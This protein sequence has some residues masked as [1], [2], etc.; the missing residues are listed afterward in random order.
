VAEL[1]RL[2]ARVGDRVDTHVLMLAPAN[3]TDHWVHSDLWRAAAAL[4]GVQ[5]A[6]DSRGEHARLF[7]SSTSGQVLLYDAGGRLQFAGGITASRGHEGGNAGRS[8]LESLIAGSP[9]TAATPVFGC[10][11]KGKGTL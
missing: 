8:A 11:L 2:L 6:I 9:A 3:Q 1:A 10:S 5:M 4:P 7:G